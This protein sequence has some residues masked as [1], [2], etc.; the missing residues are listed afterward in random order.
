V[1]GNLFYERA[2]QERAIDEDDATSPGRLLVSNR[3]PA[4]WTASN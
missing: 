3:H 2:L 4:V 1:T